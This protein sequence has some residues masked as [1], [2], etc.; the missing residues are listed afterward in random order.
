MTQYRTARSPP[1]S[2]LLISYPARKPTT[3]SSCSNGRQRR[4]DVDD[5]GTNSLRILSRFESILTDSSKHFK[6]LVTG[7]SNG[8]SLYLNTASVS[9]IGTLKC[10]IRCLLFE[11]NLR[12]TAVLCRCKIFKYHPLQVSSHIASAETRESRIPGTTATSQSPMLPL[13]MRSK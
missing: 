4:V 6:R 7:L 11:L 2:P 9:R 3:R 12:T 5:N 13:G 10:S 1:S 8:N